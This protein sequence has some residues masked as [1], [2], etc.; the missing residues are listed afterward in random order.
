MGIIAWYKRDP[1]A[2]LRGMRSLTPEERGVY[3]TILDLIYDSANELID[4]DR[5]MAGNCNCDV[6]VYRRVKKRLLHMEKLYV[7]GGY[8]RNR[9]AD[10]AVATLLAKHI[11]NRNAALIKHGKLKAKEKK[12]KDLADADAY[13]DARAKG[14]PF[15]NQSQNKKEESP[16][17]PPPSE[18]E[19]KSSRKTSW[20]DGFWLTDDMRSYAEKQTPGVDANR[21]FEKF[22]KHHQSKGSKFI[23]W[24]KAW[25]TWCLSGYA[26]PMLDTVNGANG[27]G[28]SSSRSRSNGSALDDLK[29]V[30]IGDTD[31]SGESGGRALVLDEAHERPG[32][33]PQ[34][35]LLSL[36]QSPDGPPSWFDDDGREP[37]DQRAQLVAGDRGF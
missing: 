22:S 28:K 6:R 23:S 2:A 19:K 11:S 32:G 24:E 31:A 27:H 30:A 15:K 13:A 20:P 4:D 5:F 7:E 18:G 3:N 8:L 21:D 12:N 1:S 14:V 34:G 29:Q 9:T 17:I 36:D 26:K 10:E 33:E 35:N 37:A 16:P 25:Q